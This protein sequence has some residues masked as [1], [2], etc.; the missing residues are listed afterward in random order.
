MVVT[1]DG[2]LFSWGHNG[3]GQLGQG[4]AVTNGH[5]SFP[6]KIEGPLDGVPVT[7]VACGGHHTLALSREGN[8]R[9]MYV[10]TQS[11]ISIDR[12]R[13]H[14]SAAITDTSPSWLNIYQYSVPTLS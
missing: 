12:T 10:H 8:V 2:R 6:I 1:S 3:Y 11:C 5:V 4:L 7:K 9:L 13:L 14:C